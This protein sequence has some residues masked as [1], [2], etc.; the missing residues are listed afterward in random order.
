MSTTCRGLI[1]GRLSNG[2]RLASTDCL[3]N[4]VQLP[5]APL[6]PWEPP[7][8]SFSICQRE[9]ARLYRSNPHVCQHW[10]WL[11]RPGDWWLGLGWSE[12]SSAVIKYPTSSSQAGTPESSFRI[13][14]FTSDAPFRTGQV[15]HNLL[16]AAI[17]C[18]APPDY[19]SNLVF[20]LNRAL[21]FSLPP[22]P[23]SPFWLCKLC[24]LQF[25]TGKV[26]LTRYLKWSLTGM[27]FLPNLNFKFY[28]QLKNH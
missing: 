16:T 10:Q 14:R 12:A 1:A 21:R 26:Q 27:T 2:D 3:S 23:V 15:S 20:R 17:V 28:L 4:F 9:P 22:H 13:V 11:G 6:S 25:E 8:S 18:R 19:H 7:H 24:L 5:I